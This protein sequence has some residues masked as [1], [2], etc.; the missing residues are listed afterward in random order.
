L[1]N[2]EGVVDFHVALN[3]SE[4]SVYPPDIELLKVFDKKHWEYRQTAKTIRMEANTLDSEIYKNKFNP[5]F[6]KIDTQGSEYEILEGAVETL[7][8]GVFGLLLET[9]SYPF[10]KNQK[11]VFDVMKLM[12]DSGYFLV[13]LDKGGY[14]R[15]KSVNNSTLYLGHIGV[16]DLLYFEKFDKFIA[17]E[18]TD[19]EIIK[20]ACIAD[21]YGMTDYAI[22]ILNYY[23]RFELLINKIKF[24]RKTSIKNVS[25]QWRVEKF[26]TMLK[27]TPRTPPLH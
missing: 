7:K 14:Y 19:S 26:K 21:M 8:K 4:S 18:K 25:N 20:A 15:R 1:W 27:L 24:K 12:D 6:I 16:L 22:D 17:S 9:W 23:N 2:K 5:D 11:L 3:K 10:H 13:D